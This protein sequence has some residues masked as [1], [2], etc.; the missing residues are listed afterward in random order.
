MNKRKNIIVDTEDRVL[1]SSSQIAGKCGVS[2]QTWCKWVKSG[3]APAP[4]MVGNVRKWLASDIEAWC[5]D[6]REREIDKCFE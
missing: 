6:L 3:L 2:K 1:Y 4:V 5:K